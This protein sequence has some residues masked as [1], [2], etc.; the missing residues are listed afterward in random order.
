MSKI[1]KEVLDQECIYIPVKSTAPYP[2][3]KYKCTC[4]FQYLLL[5][6]EQWNGI[7]HVKNIPEGKCMKCGKNIL[8]VESGAEQAIKDGE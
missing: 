2:C 8:V 4:G 5:E 6:S 1:N 3:Q 7:E